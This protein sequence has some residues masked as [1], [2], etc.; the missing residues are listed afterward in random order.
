MDT[1]VL[2][3]SRAVLR[4]RAASYFQPRVQRRSLEHRARQSNETV[5]IRGGWN[6]PCS[7]LPVATCQAPG[8]SGKGGLDTTITDR[9]G[10]RSKRDKIQCQRRAKAVADQGPALNSA[11]HV[12]NCKRSV[13]PFFSF[14]LL[15]CPL[16]F[17]ISAAPA[18]RKRPKE[19][20]GWVGGFCAPGSPIN[21]P[22]R[23]RD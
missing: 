16:L 20:D 11:A 5:A 19:E 13:M 21:C 22:P 4:K 6:L 2:L 10:K 1:L 8:K 14:T 17:P 23:R 18:Y 15:L 7:P 12:C 3:G 9:C